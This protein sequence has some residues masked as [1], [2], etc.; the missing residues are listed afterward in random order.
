MHSHVDRDDYVKVQLEN[1]R[2]EFH[3]AFNRV[4]PNNFHNFNTPYDYLSIM[5]YDRFSF[6]MNGRETIVPHDPRYLTLIGSND[7]SEGDAQRINN[8]YECAV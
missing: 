6:S 2:P 7:L 5:H 3:S 1:V 8:M 4:N